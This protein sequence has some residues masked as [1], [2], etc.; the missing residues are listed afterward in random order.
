M[1]VPGGPWRQTENRR[2]PVVARVSDSATRLVFARMSRGSNLAGVRSGGFQQ[3]RRR[4]RLRTPQRTVATSPPPRHAV[5]VA[6]AAIPGVISNS[7]A[8]ASTSSGSASIPWRSSCR[9]QTFALT[10]LVGGC[11][12]SA[13]TMRRRMAGLTHRASFIVQRVGA[14]AR[15]SER[16]MKTVEAV[17]KRGKLPPYWSAPLRVDRL[18]VWN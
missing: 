18:H 8:S 7:A 3:D 13:N 5:A 4:E 15:S 6:P 9:P 2:A 12:S 17:V 16:C 10:V 14:G 1:P 11:N